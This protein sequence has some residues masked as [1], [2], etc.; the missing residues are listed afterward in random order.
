MLLR[1]W[2]NGKVAG[3]KLRS[4]VGSS[5]TTRTS[6]NAHAF[7]RMGGGEKRQGADSFSD[8]AAG[9]SPT[10]RTKVASSAAK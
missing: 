1:V 9:P 10:T 7:S 5:P 8:H 3:F 4:S 2:A 6:K